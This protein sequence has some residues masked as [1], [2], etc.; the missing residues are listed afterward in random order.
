MLCSC[1]FMRRKPSWM[2]FIGL[3]G[4]VIMLLFSSCKSTASRVNDVPISVESDHF[5][6]ANV[7]QKNT[8]IKMQTING[9][10]YVYL[11]GTGNEKPS[12]YVFDEAGSASLGDILIFNR[13]KSLWND[14]V[15]GFGNGY[16]YVK[17]YTGQDSD[18][19]YPKQ[20][21]LMYF[22]LATGASGFLTKTDNAAYVDARFDENGSFYI[23]TREISPDQEKQY[24]K[25]LQD[26][27][28]SEMTSQPDIRSG[29]LSQVLKQYND[30]A[31]ML[32]EKQLNSVMASVEELGLEG[33]GCVL[34]PC[35]DGWL[36]HISTGSM[37]LCFISSDGVVTPVFEYACLDSVSSFNCYGDYGF[38]SVKRYEQWDSMNYGLLP[39]ENDTISGLYRIN[40]TDHTAEKISDNDYRGIF[41]F[42]DTSLFVCDNDGGVY[43]LDYNGNRITTV[44]EP[45][46][47]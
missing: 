43:Q 19:A 34:Y 15:L 16:M 44:V 14:V 26:T 45:Y 30:A 25:V 46:S 11:P 7:R 21:D 39:Y 47:A 18:G 29:T 32:D 5:S 6:L 42:D 22:D 23:S 2:L 35:A 1:T 24:Q 38:L 4:M 40:L 27:L 3:A 33:Y 8:D 36:L 20:A 28:L 13:Y 41:I 10:L 17:R 37:P 12:V 31:Q 9:K